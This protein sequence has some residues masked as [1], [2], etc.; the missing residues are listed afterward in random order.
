M[1]EDDESGLSGAGARYSPVSSS[2]GES[3]VDGL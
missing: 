2:I 3:G 1:G